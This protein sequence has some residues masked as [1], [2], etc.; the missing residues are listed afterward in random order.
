MPTVLL[1][2]LKLSISLA[3]V[4][5]FYQ[6]LLRRLTFYNWNR[7]YLLGYSLLAFFI[8]LVNIGSMLSGDNFSHEPLVIQ[9]IPVIGKYTPVAAGRQFFTWNAWNILG[10]VIVLGAFV[11][12]LRSVVRCLSLRRFRAQARRMD[13]PDIRIYEV[14]ERIIPFSFGNAIYINPKLHTEKEWEDIILHE[15]VHVKQRHTIDILL[16]ELLC[17]INWYNPFAWLIRLSLRQNLEFIADQ[18][19]LAGGVDKKG[20]QYH[21]LKVIG[22]P[23]YRLATNFNFSSLKKRIIMMNTI[24]SAR[25]HLVKFLFILPLISVLLVAF[26]DKYGA[27]TTTQTA[28]HPVDNVHV[29]NMNIVHRYAQVSEEP[30]HTRTL[31][32][33]VRNHPISVK[34]TGDQMDSRSKGIGSDIHAA[35]YRTDTVPV[36]TDASLNG[37]VRSD[38]KIQQ[39]KKALYVV[40]GVRMPADWKREALNPADI[41]QIEVFRGEEAMRLYGNEAEDGV[42]VITTK[43]YHKELA[44]KPIDP[45][46]VANQEPLFVVDGME[47]SHDALNSLNPDRISSITVLKNESATAKYGDKGKN[48]VVLI[49]LKK[50][51]EVI[52]RGK[53]SVRYRITVKPD[54]L[55]HQ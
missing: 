22:E 44:Q 31:I 36:N 48:G 5:L 32:K 41:Y 33:P 45:L 19:V 23:A 11:L 51:D 55:R 14:E 38:I 52:V 15:Y 17:I 25:L 13:H 27:M 39:F 53:D 34:G 49:T 26:R 21:L 24:R 46:H 35:S 20:Y 12:L 50:A 47:I 40:D 6:L 42:V 7:W 1:Y 28:S 8:P 43:S 2:L 16:A 4:W 18:Q 10:A 9:F 29:T 3:I 54:S 37:P 30:T